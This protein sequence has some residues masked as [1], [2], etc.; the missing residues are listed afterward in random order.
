M[1]FYPAFNTL[2]FFNE[3]LFFSK[4]NSDGVIRT[5]RGEIYTAMPEQKI[6]FQLQFHLRILSSNTRLPTCALFGVNELLAFAAELG[7][8]AELP[9]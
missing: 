2:F 7:V 8:P 5:T 9:G 3:L 1:R 6:S 4:R